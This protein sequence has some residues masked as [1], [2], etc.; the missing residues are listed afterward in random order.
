[1]TDRAIAMFDYP[2]DAFRAIARLEAMGVP[3][4]DISL[5]ANNGDS[6]YGDDGQI[7]HDRLAGK[8]TDAT[9]TLE[10]AKDGAAA[11]SVLG[12][13]AGLLAGLSVFAVPGAGP[14]VAAG[15]ILAIA[16][17]A[18]AG[19]VAG[20]AL[21]SVADVLNKDGVAT[22]DAEIYAEHLHRGGAL[23]IVRDPGSRRDEIEGVLSADAIDIARQRAYLHE[24]GWNA[25]GAREEALDAIALEDERRRKLHYRSLKNL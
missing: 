23:V 10:S 21:A 24:S 19:A 11:G 22:E 12:G 18:A 17:G 3:S 8:S 14:I 5:I 25:G 6:W 2:A 20:G 7:H 1:M 4:S 16:T 15:W 9:P 13:G